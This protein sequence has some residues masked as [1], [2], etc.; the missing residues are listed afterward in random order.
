MKRTISSPEPRTKS[1]PHLRLADSARTNTTTGNGRSSHSPPKI[2]GKPKHANSPVWRGV[3]G[4]SGNTHFVGAELVWD[5]DSHVADNYS[6]LG[7]QLAEAG[8]LFRDPSIGG[9]LIRL[10]PDGKHVPIKKGSELLPVIVDRVPVRVVKDGKSKGGKI[11]AA[12]LNAMLQSEVFLGHFRPVDQ[13]TTVPMYLPDFALAKP[14]YNDGGEHH[15]VI[16]IGGDPE[17][18]DSLDTINAFL[19]VM[20]FDANADRTNTVAAALTVMLRNFW[21]GNKPIICV[22]ANK[23]HSGKDT[24][25][26]FAAGL[27]RPVSISY[28]STNWALERSFVGALKQSPDTGVVVVENARLERSQRFMASAFLERFAT[29][30]EP[31]LFSTG[32]GAPVRRRN[33]VVLAIST[34]FGSVSEDL[35]NRSLPIHLSPVGDVATRTSPI[36][37]PRYEFLPANQAHIAAELRGMIERWKQAGQPLDEEARHPF[38]LWAKTIGG[39][40]HVN[41]FTDFL[42]NYGTRKAN[43]DPVRK[44][45]G[46]L[47]AKKHDEWLQA[48][49]WAKTAADQ[50]VMKMVIPEADRENDTSRARGMGVVLSAHEQEVFVVET[51]AETLTL[52]LEKHRGRFDGSEPQVRYRFVLVDRQSLSIIPEDD[53]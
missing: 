46:L 44:G 28:Q 19:D 17:I 9:G 39:I 26:S 35:L 4:V 2:G 27:S 15:R 32:T 45:L 34:N 13:V 7:K 18:S 36:G 3:V 11:D 16:Y 5:E 10:L 25:V 1:A 40:L 22:T 8:D 21:L 43:D 14:G 23:S 53:Q 50:G 29:D 20:A 41:G 48:T 49:A 12:H 42:G 37:N 31:L 38:S 52:K 33:D 24:V 47:G 51:E 6:K 30:P